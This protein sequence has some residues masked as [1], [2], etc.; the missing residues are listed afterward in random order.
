MPFRASGRG[1]YGPQGQRV[2]KGPLA[3][4]WT[5]FSPTAITTANATGY[6]YTFVASDDSGD[7][8]TYTLASGSVPTGLSLSTAGVLSGTANTSGTYTYTINA[9]DVNGR[10]TTSPSI[11]HTVTLAVSYQIALMGGGGSYPNSEQGRTGHGGCGVFTMD[12]S[13]GKVIGYVVG[14][15]ASGT[16]PG[17][18]GGGGGSPGPAGAGGGG[19]WITYPGSSGWDNIA[20]AVGGGGGG[21]YYSDWAGNGGAMN[22]NG[23]TAVDPFGSPVGGGATTSG[24]GGGYSSGSGHTGGY[25]C[26]WGA[27]G[28]GGYYGGGG[29]ACDQQGQGGTPGGGG[30]GWIS[31][32]SGLGTN[33]NVLYNQGGGAANS[34]ISGA[35]DLGGST[36]FGDANRGKGQNQ[37]GLRIW[38]A[39]TL[40]LDVGASTGSFT[41]P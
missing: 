6:S 17:S 5:T 34:G 22:G 4:V 16:T 13:P 36:Y 21:C 37:G 8:P 3:P 33:V 11:S 30:S 15:A 39:G 19:T 26:S 35:T 29:G 10:T 14:G 2:I 1:A 23:G 7:N 20:A 9:T 31:I 28:G 12:S 38:K 41:L 25:G 18:P 27:G 32:P 40:V 24:P